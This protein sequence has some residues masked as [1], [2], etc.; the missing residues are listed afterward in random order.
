MPNAFTS[1]LNSTV[2]SFLS[3]C[4]E[5]QRSQLIFTTH[6][7][8]L[9]DLDL[10]RRDEIWFFEKDAFG[11]STL[12]SMNALKVRR[13]LKLDKSYLQGRFGGIPLIRDLEPLQTQRNIVAG[14]PG[15]AVMSTASFG[16]CPQ[17]AWRARASS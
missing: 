17:I 5:D 10:L 3:R 14:P 12:Y 15:L 8:H 11:A 9:M 7:T 13:D 16:T 1:P 2:S 6:D 4:G